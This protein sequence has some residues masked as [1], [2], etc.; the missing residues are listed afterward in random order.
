[1]RIERVMVVMDRDELPP[2]SDED[3]D[4][5]IKAQIEGWGI[6][7]ENPLCDRE[8]SEISHISDKSP[9]GRGL[10]TLSG[11]DLVELLDFISHDR[12]S[13]KEQL[14]TE[15]TVMSMTNTFASGEGDI[16]PPGV[17][18]YLTEYPD[19][20]LYGPLGSAE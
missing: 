10:I 8:L 18:A 16:R 13:D 7:S 15:V 9:R 19:E 11:K 20:R 1:M 6:D 2:H 4:G 17:Y 12:G 5:W 14:D 3:F